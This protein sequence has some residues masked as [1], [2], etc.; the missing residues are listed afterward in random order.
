MMTWKF[1]QICQN[2]IVTIWVL[3]VH[4]SAWWLPVEN[5]IFVRIRANSDL[6]LLIESCV[7]AL[8]ESFKDRSRTGDLTG[9]HKNE[10][11]SVATPLMA[12][13]ACMRLG[14]WMKAWSQ[15]SP[16]PILS[17]CPPQVVCP[18]AHIF[19]FCTGAHFRAPGQEGLKTKS[20][21]A[22]TTDVEQKDPCSK[23][24]HQV[25]ILCM[26]HA[27]CMYAH[28]IMQASSSWIET[29]PKCMAIANGNRRIGVSNGHFFTH[30]CLTKRSGVCT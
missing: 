20:C 7:F 17:V 26:Q 24:C 23:N 15:F 30:F 19:V 29:K 11:E 3:F 27:A 2:W 21:L 28:V 9:E 5:N 10:T 22:S 13:S 18:C 16:R 12:I 6:Q 25:R 14:A 4:A 8:R 1:A